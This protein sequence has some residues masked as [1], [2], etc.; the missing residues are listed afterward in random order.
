MTNKHPSSFIYKSKSKLLFYALILLLFSYA[1]NAYAQCTDPAGVAANMRYDETDQRIEYCDGTDWVDSSS[2]TNASAAL[3]I[4]GSVFDTA[5]LDDAS[6]VYVVG[7]YAYVTAE[8]DNALT[9]VD[10]S[11]PTA[12]TIVG[13]VS[14]IRL[15]FATGVFVIGNYAY[16]TSDIFEMLTVVDISTPTAP[17]IVGHVS[18]TQ[19]DGANDV[20]VVGNYAYVAASISDALTVVD[21]STPTAPTIVGSVS[22]S[23]QLDQPKDVFVVGNYAYVTAESDDALTV[24]DVDITGGSTALSSGPCTKAG[25]M[26]YNSTNN[27]LEFCDGTQYNDMGVRGSGFGG[28]TGIT[29]TPSASA[30]RYNTATNIY[31]FCDGSGWVTVE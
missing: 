30:L 16:V 15:G 17:T 9:V 21:I 11:T 3:T 2:E 1:Q 14:S 29:P 27:V 23:T 12:P 19:L 13:S 7:N 10:I 26:R 4:E 20:F 28:C 18:S 8:N 6:N 31:E 5:T 25:E 24:V 22:S